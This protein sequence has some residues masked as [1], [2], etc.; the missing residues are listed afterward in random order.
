MTIASPDP[1]VQAQH[2]SLLARF[3]QYVQVE[4][5]ADPNS[6]AVPSTPGQLELGRILLSQLQAMELVNATQ[7]PF[8]VVRAYLPS[9]GL[10]EAEAA[11]L[12]FNSHIDTAPDASGRD[13]RPQV[14]FY[15][16]G[17]IELPNGLR[18]TTEKTPEL[19]KLKGKTL[20]TTNGETLLG[21]DDKAG[22]AII[23]EIARHLTSNPSFPR[24]NVLF[25]FTC[26]EEIG[27]GVA[28]I[29]VAGLNGTVAYTFDGGGRG[30]VNHA[31]FSANAAVVDFQGVNIHPAIAKNRMINAVRGVG[32]F[33]A[34]LP[35]DWSPECT[36]GDDGFLHPYEITGGVASVRLRLILRDFATEKLLTQE[37]C[38]RNAAARTEEAFPGLQVKVSV[39][40]QYRNMEEG[41]R[42][43]PRAMQ[44][45]LRAHELLNI[46]PKLE[47]IRGGTDGS[48]FTA[49]GLPTP[50]LSS[51]QHNIHSPL[52]F[53]CLDEMADAYE[54]GLQLVRLWSNE[55]RVAPK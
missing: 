54:I 27:R 4:T 32:H 12:V 5:T 23:M 21:G 2:R 19:N 53:A 18:I 8:G 28:S 37:T 34:Q 22:V 3:L 45:A 20:I 35:P 49:N 10:P 52:E 11:T 9:N 40:P 7:D 39:H 48:Q 29:D 41:L 15:E 16:G 55:P 42:L 44:L 38:L 1:N 36:E 31:T 14:V 25:L 50:N 13:V 30:I 46:T 51:G 17:D 6:A 43:E 24:P 26:D 47:K 33:L